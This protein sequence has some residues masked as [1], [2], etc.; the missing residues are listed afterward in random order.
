MQEIP[1]DIRA[2]E[3]SDIDFLMEI[4]N[5]DSLL[6]TAYARIPFSKNTLETYLSTPQ[7]I[8]AHKQLRLIA[9]V[10]GKACA[11]I[12]FYDFDAYHQRAMIGIVVHK[13]FRKLGIGKKAL[14]QANTFAKNNLGLRNVGAFVGVSNTPSVSLFGGAGYKQRGKFKKY[15]RLVNGTYDDLLIYQ[16]YL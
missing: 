15:H 9:A 11:V 1:L 14:Q 12:D 2:V 4:E 13:Q 8:Y 5:D 10:E 3:P 6:D 7:D 16:K